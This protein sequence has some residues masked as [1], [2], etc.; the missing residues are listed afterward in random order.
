MTKPGPRALREHSQVEIQ[1]CR[2]PGLSVS[3]IDR[4][5][6]TE[7]AFLLLV[8]LASGSLGLSQVSE[9]QAAHLVELPR[10]TYSSSYI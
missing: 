3:Q 8:G 2:D 6:I 10:S 9:T 4:E 7:L 1:A 5:D